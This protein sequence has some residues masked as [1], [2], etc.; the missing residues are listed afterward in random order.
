MSKTILVTV[1]SGFIGSHL[2][3]SLSKD[4]C[5]WFV[6]LDNNSTGGKANHVK[7]VKYIRGEI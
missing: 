1:G 7:S 2:C 3:E 5:N 6:S 4:S